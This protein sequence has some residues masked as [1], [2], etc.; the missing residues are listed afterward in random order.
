MVLDVGCGPGEFC[1]LV[2]GRGAVAHGLD[3]MPDRIADARRRVPAGDFRAFFAFLT[4]LDRTALDPD[5]ARLDRLP[6]RDA[7]DRALDR[8][9]LRVAASGEVPAVMTLSGDDALASALASAGAA[10]GPAGPTGWERRVA[11]AASPWRQPDG[12]YRFENRFKCRVLE[13]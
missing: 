6:E 4:A 11:A 12:S 1:H 3:G 8:L 10:A 9:A 2:A 7:V 5:G 13:P